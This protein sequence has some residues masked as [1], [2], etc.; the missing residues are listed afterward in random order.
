M[1]KTFDDLCQASPM[2][3]CVRRAV[4]RG[5]GKEGGRE[6][7]RGSS[8]SGKFSAGRE[9]GEREITFKRPIS[10]TP[11]GGGG[12]RGGRKGGREGE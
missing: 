3:Q 9:G 1:N 2:P 12:G 8:G 10:T 7:G 4:L 11:V 6:G 5:G